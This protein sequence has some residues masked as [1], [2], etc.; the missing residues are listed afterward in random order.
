MANK[1]TDDVSVRLKLENG[2]QFNKDAKQSGKS[3][4]GV[5]ADAKRT[6]RDLGVASRASLRL[7]TGLLSLGVSARNGAALGIAAAGAEVV[8]ATRG[9][10][11]HM[12]VVRRT[13][14]VIASTGGVARVTSDHVGSLSDALEKQ[15][16]MD[17]DLIQS[18]ANLLLTFTNVRNGVGKNNQVF[19]EATKTIT[20][21]S[22]ALGQSTKTSAIQLGKALN[23]PIKGVTALQKVGVSFDASQKK[24]IETLVK[25]GQTMKAQKII[26]AELNKEFPR[27]KA[28]P[29]ER[30]MVT[31]HA[32]E[33]DLGSVFLPLSNQ[34]FKE[35]TKLG[36]AIEPSV[37]AVAT[38]LNN[39]FARGDIDLGAKLALSLGSV[40]HNLGPF[41]QDFEVGLKNAGLDQKFQDAVAW[42][43]PRI[44]AGARTAGFSTAEAFGKAFI[45]ADPLG[46]LL[47]GGYLL[48]KLGAGGALAKGLGG[49]LSG[50]G[51][52]GIGG[53]FAGKGN[54]P[55]NP[56]FVAVI[57]DLPGKGG[58]G[59][60]LD[61]VLKKG[62][63]GKYAG[64]ALPAA[65]ATAATAGA[66]HAA[67]GNGIPTLKG[68]NDIINGINAR[69]TDPR[70][71]AALAR[72]ALQHLTDEYSAPMKS[73]LDPA[74]GKAKQD[75]DRYIA[76]QSRGAAGDSWLMSLPALTNK[77]QSNNVFKSD[78]ARTTQIIQLV[79]PNG[80]V[81]AEL[82]NDENTKKARG[83]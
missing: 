40:R 66:L 63:W 44:A 79:L 68:G 21:M 70:Q 32:L 8:R 83:R 50:K 61:D 11:D 69:T 26:L 18:G 35:L 43:I 75:L 30:M 15:T 20:G 78:I 36:D 1:S 58:K 47:I 4:R 14:A 64:L 10:A 24:Q 12:A 37:G 48:K 3:I 59:G 49:L 45:K 2:K 73:L 76:A 71:R 60:I 31:V 33:D 77:P 19:D 38:D 5:G 25:T 54:T 46:Q 41:A 52:G 7:R 74:Y 53:L 29:F 42:A 16:G 81:L 56:L 39:I 62:K 28:T 65:A 51:K 22:Q 55:A 27:V 82:V 9:Y 13:N 72:Q 23:D 80:K 67:T 17:G 6:S 34:L 57:N